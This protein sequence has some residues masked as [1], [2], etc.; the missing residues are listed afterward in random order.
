MPIVVLLRAVS[1]GVA[2]AALLLLVLRAY[3]DARDRRAAARARSAKLHVAAASGLV[4]EASRKSLPII[5]LNADPH[6][7]DDDD[8]DDP[9][10]ASSTVPIF[11]DREAALDEPTRVKPFI[12]VT[13]AGQTDQGL[14]RPRNEDSL[15]WLIDQNVFG[16]ADG[17]GGHAGG[18]VASKMAVEAISKA[19]TTNTFPG[20][21]YPDLPR[22][23]AELAA[24]IQEGN[25]A[26]YEFAR[27]HPKYGGMGTTVVIARFSP[28]KQRMY[29]GHVGDSR[30]YRIRQGVMTQIT[31]DHTAGAAGVTGPLASRLQRAVG[32]S[33]SLKIDLITA[34]P[35]PDDMYLLCTDGLT[36]MV[37]DEVIQSILVRAVNMDH[38]VH[39]LIERANSSGGCDNITAVLLQV[40][41][42][43]AATHWHHA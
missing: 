28:N 36:K 1:L 2:I 9:Q 35:Q 27:A 41:D 39:E 24:A 3:R 14:L 19:F 6:D 13:A 18:D 32:V 37:S 31:T 20:T 23:G 11:Y 12:L 29:V 34:R 40:K 25:T 17:M 26:I 4:R 10:D 7:G 42:P 33:P 22:R 15:L 5:R 38:A 30:C 43:K 8:D 21:P 16:V